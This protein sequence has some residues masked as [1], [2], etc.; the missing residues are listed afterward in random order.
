MVEDK[1]IDVD[2]IE[3]DNTFGISFILCAYVAVILVM[4]VKCF[5]FIIA[6]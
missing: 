2:E 3:H 6:S 1:N 5:S 4:L